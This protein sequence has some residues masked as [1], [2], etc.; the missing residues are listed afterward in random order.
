MI[1]MKSIYETLDVYNIGMVTEAANG[2]ILDNSTQP[3]ILLYLNGTFQVIESGLSH[4]GILHIGGIEGVQ[5]S[6]LCLIKIRHFGAK[7]GQNRP[8]LKPN[9]ARFSPVFQPKLDIF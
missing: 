4:V 7:F 2:Q 1:G 5:C 6:Q 3:E 8:L 9:F